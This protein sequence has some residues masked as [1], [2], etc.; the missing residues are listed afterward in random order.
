MYYIYRITNLI[1]GKTYIG[2]HKYKSL[3]DTYMGSGTMLHLAYKKY[4]IENFIKDVLVFGIIDKKLIDMMEREYIA[5]E[6]KCNTNGCYNIADGGDGGNT[7]NKGK[8]W[9]EEARKKISEGHMGQ[10]AWNKGKKLGHLSEETKQKMSK[11]LKGHVF[12]D[13][14]K[15]KISDALK[16]IHRSEETRRKI[17]EAGKGKPK[18]EETKQK[19]R[20]AHKRRRILKEKE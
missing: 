2:Q 18:S 14:A 1:N 13:E 10:I 20:E 6:R 16:G 5:L 15:R 9:S 4:G 12:S 11:A 19:M 7:W 17:S 8:H 3:N